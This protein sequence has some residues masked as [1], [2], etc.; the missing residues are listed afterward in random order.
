MALAET[1]ITD[2]P[3]AREPP[4]RP[5]AEAMLD[6]FPKLLLDHAQLRPEAPA[7]REKDYGIWQS[8][9]WAQAAREIEEFA[10]GLAVL[11]FKRGDKLAVVGDNRPRL[12]WAI[13]AAQCLGGVPVPIYQDSVAAETKFVL[14]HAEARFA[15]AENQEQ[16]DK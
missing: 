2:E 13:A 11:G 3:G 10:A 7:V 12:Y 1:A 8:W 5:A 6:T 14:D 4:P 15:V 16:V 9:S